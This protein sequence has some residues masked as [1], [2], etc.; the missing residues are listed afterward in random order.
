MTVCEYS[1][2]FPIG[3]NRTLQDTNNHLQH[4]NVALRGGHAE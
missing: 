4:D 1:E 3:T 2:C